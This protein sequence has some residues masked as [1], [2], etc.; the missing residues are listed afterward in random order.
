MIDVLN[1]KKQGRRVT[2]LKLIEIESTHIS[3]ACCLIK[4]TP[5]CFKSIDSFL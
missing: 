2:K 5:P 3:L 4:F 1:Y